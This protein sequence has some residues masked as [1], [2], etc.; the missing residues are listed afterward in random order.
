MI[1]AWERV[2]RKI[3]LI[4]NIVEKKLQKQQKK[5]LRKTLKK[6]ILVLL[7]RLRNNLEIRLK[8]F[9]EKLPV[10]W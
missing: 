3:T 6:H 2:I 4:F 1:H 5:L 10:I 9:I 7:W 8:I